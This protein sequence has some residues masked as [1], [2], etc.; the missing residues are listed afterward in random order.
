MLEAE[1]IEIQNNKVVE[2]DK[3]FWDPLKELDL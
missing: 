2:F 1:G 3:L